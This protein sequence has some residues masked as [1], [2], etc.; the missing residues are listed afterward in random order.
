MIQDL[1]YVELK[2]GYSDDGPAWIGYVKTSKSKKTIYFNDHAF[3][4]YSG[5]CS[6]YVDVEN[7][8]AYWITGVKKRESNRHWSGHGK[9]MIDRRAV[10]EYLRHIG[11][12][13]LPAS[14]FEIIDIE[15]RFPVERV[16]QLLNTRAEPT[17]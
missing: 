5:W 8:D 16:R 4:K 10:E 12:S 3:Q 14:A 13:E 7:G 11:E 15:D 2:T 17:E 9:I 1:M 6:N